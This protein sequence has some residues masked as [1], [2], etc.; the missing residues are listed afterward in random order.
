[1]LQRNDPTGLGSAIGEGA[2]TPPLFSHY[3]ANPPPVAISLPTLPAHPCPYLPGR[4]ARSRALWAPRLPG[5]LYQHFMEAGFRRSGKLVYQPVCAG[6]RACRPLR[7]PVGSFIP[8]KSQRRCRRQNQGLSVTVASPEAT[9]ETFDLY[10]RYVQQWHGRQAEEDSRSAFEEFLYQSPVESLEFKYREESGN[11]IA[12]GICDVSRRALSSVYF[13]FDPQESRRSLGT[14]GALYELE[15]ARAKQIEYYYL[16]YW[17]E[18][19][20]TMHYK[21]RFRPYELLGNDG[22]WLPAR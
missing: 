21:V 19:C 20:D 16:G 8:D 14:F 10:R 4:T 17:I 22:N 12:V 18:G 2:R 11:L 7:V 13:Y 1:M 9:D 15:F 5:N 3:P 6:C